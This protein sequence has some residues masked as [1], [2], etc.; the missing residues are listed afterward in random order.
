MAEKKDGSQLSTSEG[1]KLGRVT[2]TV[3]NLYRSWSGTSSDAS[4]EKLKGS[5]GR[6]ILPSTTA[7]PVRPNDRRFS[8]GAQSRE[9][10]N[11]SELTLVPSP[12]LNKPLPPT[13]DESKHV[14]YQRYL[15]EQ[16]LTGGS[17]PGIRRL[18][19][20]GVNDVAKANAYTPPPESKSHFSVSTV[21][22]TESD[23]SSR[24]SRNNTNAVEQPSAPL[25]SLRS[26]Q[27]RASFDTSTGLLARTGRRAQAKVITIP[28]KQGAR[29]LRDPAGGGSRSG[30]GEP[31]L[32]KPLTYR[33][34]GNSAASSASRRET[35]KIYMDTS[36]ES[37]NRSRDRSQ[38][39]GRG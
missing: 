37:P 32:L 2:K 25:S 36:A 4:K 29:D 18:G 13:P 1:G 39:G 21:A 11:A 34:E 19:G 5:I 35:I 16:K 6:P 20:R 10:S 15:T 24:L 9:A 31:E 33:G 38:D 22:S 26:S 14:Q 12:D 23:A 28:S 17:P 7:P 27:L 3:L 30:I 8:N